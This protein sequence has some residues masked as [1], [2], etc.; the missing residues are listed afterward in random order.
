M[1]QGD[2]V[3]P[4]RY[5]IWMDMVLADWASQSDPYIFSGT[6]TGAEVHGFAWVDDTL[7]I[8][9]TQAGVNARLQSY[10][11]FLR[12]HRVSIKIP[13]TYYVHTN[14]GSNE[15]PRP[16]VGLHLKKLPTLPNGASVSMKAELNEGK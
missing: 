8:S 3:S 14:A 10:A 4:L 16:S 11:S 5:I 2:S 15:P 12:A 1:R 7:P 13:K 9:S 6:P